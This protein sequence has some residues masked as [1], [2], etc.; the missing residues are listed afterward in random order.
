MSV[1]TAIALL[2]VFLAIA[3]LELSQA[4]QQL[5]PTQA[6][7]LESSNDALP[8][9][10]QRIQ[11]GLKQIAEDISTVHARMLQEPRNGRDQTVSIASRIHELLKNDDPAMLIR[12]FLNASQDRLLFESCLKSGK[13]YRNLA[14]EIFRTHLPEGAPT[15]Q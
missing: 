5:L 4:G 1:R 10:L 14:S 6:A 11:M 15:T 9:A 12:N 7:A 13:L 2:N 8:K 3:S